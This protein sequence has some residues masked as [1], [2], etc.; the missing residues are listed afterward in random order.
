M[1]SRTRFIIALGVVSTLLF[2]GRTIVIPTL[3][4]YARHFKA[5]DGMIG[6]LIAAN[7]AARLALDIPAGG[8][9]LRRNPRRWLLL[10]LGI[11][12][13]SSVAAALATDYWMLLL[14]RMLEGA[15]ASVYIV[16]ALTMM[17]QATPT[18]R[19]GRL[20]AVY[21]A[22]IDGGTMMGPLVGGFAAEAFGLAA[23]FY[24]YAALVA[25]A[26]LWTAVILRIPPEIEASPERR[27]KHATVAEMIRL[28]RTPHLPYVSLAILSLFFTRGAISQTAVPLFA[29]D[30]LGASRA[31]AGILLTA[32]NL[33][34]LITTAPSGALTDKVGRK[35]MTMLAILSTAIIVSIM[36]F[37]PTMEVFLIIMALYG[38]S[39]GLSGPNAAWFLDIS[40]PQMRGTAMGL[41]RLGND[42]GLF[43]GPAVA[44]FLLEAS[45]SPEGTVQPHVFV[46]T[47]AFLTLSF[48][49]ASRA[50]DPVRAQR[51]GA[52]KDREGK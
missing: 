20:L 16:S 31:A 14:A 51:K 6:G 35:P 25:G 1:E 42:L 13:S 22:M 27:E 5:T 18:S 38:I 32:V 21:V 12:F 49:L 2:M 29:Y 34:S 37:S 26:M 10:G 28:I 46:V 41:Y 30:N 8:L 7:G 24:L 39:L 43:A 19:R 9:A 17:G 40:P 15:G 3:P 52:R 44:G 23:P 50:H 45:R 47:A 36:P 11:V 33:A 4:L 48:A